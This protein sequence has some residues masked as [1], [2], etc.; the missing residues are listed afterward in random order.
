M[1]IMASARVLSRG[2]EEAGGDVCSDCMRNAEVVQDFVSPWDAFFFVPSRVDLKALRQV[3]QRVNAAKTVKIMKSN[4][5]PLAFE[6]N[7]ESKS[8][9]TIWYAKLL[10]AVHAAIAYVATLYS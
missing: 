8:K 10:V 9:P 5:R 7:L 1:M 2:I 3:A 4:C 6:A